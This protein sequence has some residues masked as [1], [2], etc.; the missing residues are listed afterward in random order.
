[1]PVPIRPFYIATRLAAG[2]AYLVPVAEVVSKKLAV[3]L[4]DAYRYRPLDFER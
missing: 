2:L 1:V 4:A 3:A